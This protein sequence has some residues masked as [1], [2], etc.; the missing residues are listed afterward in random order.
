MK[1]LL[2]I[3]LALAA[4]SLVN[5]GCGDGC[6]LGGNCVDDICRC[7]DG[8]THD[9]QSNVCVNVNECEGNPCGDESECVDTF[10]SFS[11]PC[12]TGMGHDDQGS[13]SVVTH[14]IEQYRV[15]IKTADI[16]YAGTVDPIEIVL[17]NRL[18]QEV[19]RGDIASLSGHTQLASGKSYS[20]DVDLDVTTLEGF[21]AVGFET[22][23]TNGWLYEYVRLTAEDGSFWTFGEEYPPQDGQRKCESHE[24]P[25]GCNLWLDCPSTC[26]FLAF[27]DGYDFPDGSTDET[28]FNEFTLTIEVE[29]SDAFP[30]AGSQDDITLTLYDDLGFEILV[31][32]L[33]NEAHLLGYDRSGG[34]PAGSIATVV[35]NG[36]VAQ[37]ARAEFKANGEDGWM[38]RAITI[39]ENSGRV[40]KSNPLPY[41][42]PDRR[43]KAAENPWD[44]ACNLWLD[45]LSP[46]TPVCALNMLLQRVS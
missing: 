11:C 36:H 14:H 7:N 33:T 21:G 43:C 35:V 32:S 45:C 29:T 6:S 4:L 34:L 12:V 28:A 44:N 8:F 37:V 20:F 27:P 16:L 46:N 39:T 17:Y 24:R 3:G 18:L 10:G 38:P 2:K 30:N 1:S 5:C 41:V 22:E 40:W 26:S 42:T 13:C 15:E 23:G 19:F 31:M 25:P 9:S